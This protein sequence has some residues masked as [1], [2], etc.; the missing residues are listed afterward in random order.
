MGYKILFEDNCFVKDVASST[1]TFKITD[2]ETGD[3]SDPL[4]SSN[5]TIEVNDGAGNYSVNAGIIKIDNAGG[6]ID[7]SVNNE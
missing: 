4:S 3:Y 7:A 6:S 1:L 2:T 5:I